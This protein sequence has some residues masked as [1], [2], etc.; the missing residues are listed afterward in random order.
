MKDF[1]ICSTSSKG[2]NPTWTL[3]DHLSSSLRMLVRFL[4]VASLISALRCGKNGAQI[5]LLFFFSTYEQ[6]IC[7]LIHAHVSKTRLELIT[8]EIL[9]FH[10]SVAYYSQLLHLIIKFLSLDQDY[11]FSNLRQEICKLKL[12]ENLKIVLENICCVNSGEFCRWI[13]IQLCESKSG[14]DFSRRRFR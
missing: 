8:T 3:E 12:A 14:C 13:K 7:P 5:I 10:E 6:T 2:S 11:C 4:A 1:E 9:S